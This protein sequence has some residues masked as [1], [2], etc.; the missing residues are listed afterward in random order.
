MNQTSPFNLSPKK[1]KIVFFSALGL[2]FLLVLGFFTKGFLDGKKTTD[3]PQNW[4]SDPEVSKIDFESF[5][6]FEEEPSEPLPEGLDT[7]NEIAETSPET[8]D[9]TPHPQTPIASNLSENGNAST[10]ETPSRP[11]PNQPSTP[12]Q[13]PPQLPPL[14]PDPIELTQ[15]PKLPKPTAPSIPSTQSAKHSTNKPCLLYTSPSPRD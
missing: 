12:N 5:G 14:G 9:F 15:T 11:T 7:P 1:L 8:S 13:R 4:D 10:A 6:Q 2:F 3:G